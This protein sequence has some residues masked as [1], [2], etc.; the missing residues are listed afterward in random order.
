MTSF[1]NLQ[2]VTPRGSPFMA[3][4]DSYLSGSYQ[5]TIG[6]PWF[7]GD[8]SSL[9]TNPVGSGDGGGVPSDPMTKELTDAESYISRHYPVSTQPDGSH[10]MLHSVLGDGAVWVF[11]IVAVLPTVR[12]FPS[13]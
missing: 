1:P 7:G 11:H 13:F 2:V 4:G 8:L 9:Y 5:N 12:V 10:M 3:S 6:R